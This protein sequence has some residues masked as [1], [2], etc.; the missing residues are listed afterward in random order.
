MINFYNGFVNCDDKANVRNVADHINYVKNLIGV[1]HIGIGSDYDG[2]PDT[3]DDL[4]DVSKFPNLFKE[5]LDNGWE[6]EDLVKIAGANILRVFSD[7]EKVNFYFNNLNKI[8][9]Y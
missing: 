6:E 2:V 1:D 5:L 8:A 7:V 4:E 3:P 9:F